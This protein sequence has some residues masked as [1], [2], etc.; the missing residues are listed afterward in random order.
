M[1]NSLKKITI[2]I[3]SLFAIAFFG[4]GFAF[5]ATASALSEN[6]YVIQADKIEADLEIRTG[7]TMLSGVK[8]AQVPATVA[9]VKYD[10]LTEEEQ[11]TFS[12]D[13]TVLTLKKEYL[14]TLENGTYYFTAQ[15]LSGDYVAKVNIITDNWVVRAAK[16]SV[17]DNGNYVDVTLNR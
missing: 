2:M 9:N 3:L 1:Q 13:T 14:Q 8:V 5:G 17:K 4:Q 7:K 16:G 15:F 12:D 11:Y 10:D 6:E